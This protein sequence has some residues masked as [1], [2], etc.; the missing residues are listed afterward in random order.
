MILSPAE[1][2]YL[3]DSLTASPVIRPDGRKHFQFRPV[4]AKI[5][6][7]P[8]SN[9]SSRIRMTD[10][11]ECIVSVKAKVVLIAKED[12][13]VECDVDL[14]GFR[15]DSNFVSNLKFNLTDLFTKN[16]P[17]QKL[18]LTSKYAY[19]LFIDCV[20]VSHLSYP[21]TLITFSAY[22]A[23]KATR[24]PLLTSEIDDSEIEEQPTFSDDWERAQSLAEIFGMPDF[25]PPLVV[26]VGVIGNNLIVDPSETEE[27]VLENGLLLGWY[28]GKVISPIS[29]LNLATSSNNVN[30]RGINLSLLVRTISLLGSHCSSLIDAFD[31]LVEDDLA[32]NDGSIF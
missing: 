3:H 32:D 27:Q 12:N 7:L 13:L 6:F 18:H 14:A 26:T 4:E 2:S 20:V 5:D 23:L 31:K 17:T 22:L 11:S 8:G 25:Q 9:G 29:N 30:F 21:L 15:D 16:F 28:N 10:G 1:R 19:K 24:L